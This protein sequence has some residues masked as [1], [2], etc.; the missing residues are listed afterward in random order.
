MNNYVF[1]S[2]LRSSNIG[3]H[4]LCIDQ[5]LEEKF[6]DQAETVLQFGMSST[7]NPNFKALFFDLG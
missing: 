6:Q 3:D 2:S 5:F 4:S 7:Q 1:W